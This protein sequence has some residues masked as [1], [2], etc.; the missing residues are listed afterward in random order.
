[1]SPVLEK[2]QLTEIFFV[3]DKACRWEQRKTL[4]SRGHRRCGVLDP[5]PRASRVCSPR[6]LLEMQNLSPTQTLQV[7]TCISQAC[8]GSLGPVKFEKHWSRDV[9]GFGH[10]EPAQTMS[11]RCL[12]DVLRD[13]LSSW[14]SATKVQSLHHDGK[15]RE[16][17]LSKV[18]GVA[19]KLCTKF[20]CLPPTPSSLP[21]PVMGP[22]VPDAGRV[23][24]FESA[25]ARFS[26]RRATA[27]R[28]T[29][30]STLA[31]GP[32]SWACPP[33]TKRTA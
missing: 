30:W 8:R 7:R 9:C 1:M 21:G 33:E 4:K 2:G 18:T 20:P 31:S 15:S 24:A 29:D 14:Q 22:E 25:W 19:A 11:T 13:V 26:S 6:A 27:S 28:C 5:D 3:L 10:Q 16:H 17:A 23:A 12:F 32:A